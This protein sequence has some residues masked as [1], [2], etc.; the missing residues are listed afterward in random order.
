MKWIDDPSTEEVRSLE[1]EHIHELFEPDE[2]PV[3][4]T[5]FLEE[6]GDLEI[7][8]PW[9]E[10]ERVASILETSGFETYRTQDDLQLAL[11]NGVGRNAVGRPRYSDRSDDRHHDFDR[12]NRSF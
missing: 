11:L 8:Y 3:T 9:G 2:F 1:A 6:Y 12:M 5:E 7:E 10:S 4:T